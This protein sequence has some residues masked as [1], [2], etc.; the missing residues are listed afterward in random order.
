M[1]LVIGGLLVAADRVAVNIAEDRTADGLRSSQGLDATPD[2][3][4]HGFP[5]LT[6]LAGGELEDVGLGIPEFP[7]SGADGRDMAVEDLDV[8]LG[9]VRLDAGMTP[10]RAAEV[11]GTG[12]IRYDQLLKAARSEPQDVAP[13][14]SAAVV[15]LSHGGDGRIKLTVRPSLLGQELPTVDVLS[16]VDVEDGEL[17]VRADALPDLGADVADRTVRSVT[18]FDQALADLP[19]GLELSEVDP[20]A[21]GVRITV[22]GK[23]VNLS[24]W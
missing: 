24:G 18:D 21:D 13:G 11:D 15:G 10:S 19:D 14:V 7:V 1:V 8:R 17:R 12:L 22:T 3:T 16:R 20:T 9:G 5:F 4:I 23:D 6:Q 2:V